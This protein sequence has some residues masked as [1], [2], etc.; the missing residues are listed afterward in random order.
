M[1][2]YISLAFNCVQCEFDYHQWILTLTHWL[3]A[4]PPSVFLGSYPVSSQLYLPR[5]LRPP[6][7]AASVLM[8][9][10]A[11]HGCSSPPFLL[12]IFNMS[13][14]LWG[15]LTQNKQ[16][17]IKLLQLC[18]TKNFPA[19]FSKV[20]FYFT[21]SLRILI[22]ENMEL[23]LGNFDVETFFFKIKK[24]CGL[25]PTSLCLPGPWFYYWKY[26]YVDYAELMS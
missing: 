3:P 24:S 16:T 17:K 1:L 25:F 7:P 23:T 19:V 22:L 6:P 26:Q 2:F 13:Q 9:F 4:C 15:F 8:Q 5:E 11:K 12:Y 14:W 18:L 20:P 10:L 21:A